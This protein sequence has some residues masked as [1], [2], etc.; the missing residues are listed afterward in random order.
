VPAIAGLHKKYADKA[1]ALVGISADGDERTLKTFVDMNHM[2]W[3][4]YL[5]L[6]E[7][8]TGAF[9]V[10]SFPTYIVV[11]KEGVVRYRESGFG[12]AVEGELEDSINKA[13]K[14]PFP[15]TGGAK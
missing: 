5:D 4:E 14:K 10:D 1:F 11:D 15:P 2:T 13:L 9:N 7:T 3:T 12:P 6:P 8:M